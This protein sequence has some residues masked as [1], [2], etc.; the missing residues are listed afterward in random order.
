LKLFGEIES[1]SLGRCRDLKPSMDVV[2]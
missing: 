1:Q 2:I